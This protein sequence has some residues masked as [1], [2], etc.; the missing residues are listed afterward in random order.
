MLQH[1][2][3]YAT[4]VGYDENL[5]TD[6]HQNALFAPIPQITKLRCFLMLADDGMVDLGPVA[7]P[8]SEAFPGST[9]L[10]EYY[11]AAAV[12]RE[13]TNLIGRSLRRWLPEII[14]RES[15]FGV[16]CGT[17]LLPKHVTSVRPVLLFAKPREEDQ[18][19]L[20]VASYSL[21][22]SDADGVAKVNAALASTAKPDRVDYYGSKGEQI[23]KMYREFVP[24]QYVPDKFANPTGGKSGYVRPTVV[25]LMASTDD[26]AALAA[27]IAAAAAAKEAANGDAGIPAGD[28]PPAPSKRRWKHAIDG[29]RLIIIMHKLNPSNGGI[30]AK[31][32][33]AVANQMWEGCDIGP[34]KAAWS[35]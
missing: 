35:G 31:Q 14:K 1:G 29:P 8:P 18:H 20:L 17:A 34:C 27:A 9:P 30:T 4:A 19:Y 12:E 24:V 11:T 3:G 28:E 13:I 6:L 2:S 33:K 23:S 15:G 5:L 21:F 32:W 16:G 22:S 25:D 7:T 26:R 10:S